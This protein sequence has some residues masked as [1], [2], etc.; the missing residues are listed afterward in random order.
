MIHRNDDV[1][2][3]SRL[4]Q[5][6]QHHPGYKEKRRRNNLQGVNSLTA[7]RSS[8][9]NAE[10]GLSP[11]GASDRKDKT[12]NGFGTSNLAAPLGPSLLAAVDRAGAVAMMAPLG[13]AVPVSSLTLEPTTTAPFSVL[14][15]CYFYAIHHLTDTK[16]QHGIARNNLVG[17]LHARLDRRI[18][19]GTRQTTRSAPWLPRQASRASSL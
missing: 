17:A 15:V 5:R 16:K 12:G 4:P 3:S 2:D 14:L 10:R 13:C 9:E 18:A 7:P 6:K 8:Q 11:P 19:A 1:N